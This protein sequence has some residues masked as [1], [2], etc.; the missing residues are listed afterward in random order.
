M[1]S[2][3]KY[4]V[5][6][7]VSSA[8]VGLML[9][10]DQNGKPAWQ[11]TDD[12]GIPAQYIPGEMNYAGLNP[13]S[14]FSISQNS[15]H[16]GI[17][18]LVYQRGS[19]MYLASMGV[20]CRKK[21]EVKI[22][23][24]CVALSYGTLP[25][26]TSLTNAGFE[27]YASSN[28]TSW[29]KAGLGTMSQEG[30][31]IQSGSYSAKWALNTNTGSLTQTL[32]NHHLMVGK[33]LT[34]T[35]YSRRSAALSL[36]TVGI[37][38][39]DV[40]V[41]H[42]HFDAN[43]DTWQQKTVTYTV[44]D[45][46]DD[47]ATMKVQ[48]TCEEGGESGGTNVYFDTVVA[49][50]DA[51]PS[52]GATTCFC[53][54]KTSIYASY[55]GGVGSYNS[56]TEAI[57]Y[58]GGMPM[59]PTWLSYW[60]DSAGTEYL[61]AFYTDKK[62]WSSPDAAAWTQITSVT[63][64]ADIVASGSDTKLWSALQHDD[65]RSASTPTSAFT[66]PTNLGSPSKH[67]HSLVVTESDIPY[68][69]KEDSIF[70]IDADGSHQILNDLKTNYPFRMAYSW[71]NNV[72]FSMGTS[73][74]KN[75]SLCIYNSLS[76]TIT[77]ISPAD[78]ASG[79]YE[80]TGA[81]YAITG[82][83]NWLYV[84][85]A[86]VGGVYASGSAG[87]YLL[88]GRWEDIEGNTQWV[89]HP[90]QIIYCY[91]TTSN[92]IK[93]PLIYNNKMF[94]PYGIDQLNV[95]TPQ[96]A[97][98]NVIATSGT[99]FTQWFD[100][101]FP[102]ENKAFITLELFTQNLDAEHTIAVSYQFWGAQT[103]NELDLAANWTTLATFNT[104]PTQTKFF[105]ANTYGKKIRFRLIFTT[106]DTVSPILNDFILKGVLRSAYRKRF[107]F[108]IR[109]SDDIVDLDGGIS[110]KTGAW[111]STQLWTARAAYWPMNLKYDGTTYTV[112][113][114]KLVESTQMNEDNRRLERLFQ[115]DA[116]EY[117]LS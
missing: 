51:Q 27:T 66:S 113:I 97:S 59:N 2:K 42:T 35:A 101:G 32:S 79:F 47:I 50:V 82:D 41:A 31:I 77:N 116:E 115:I 49:T 99:L 86:D 5:E 10:K 46:A 9:A 15:W 37:L 36:W 106:D 71:Q 84:M 14:G 8:T 22:G 103:T 17:G 70:Y 95:L 78:Y 4:D 55:G 108:A 16:G 100:L 88:A 12:T 92:N 93:V 57:D 69:F 102:G 53:E 61:I 58:I 63:T 67:I 56:T 38:R 104:S 75:A 105:A 94:L 33:L 48:L 1:K 65:I 45:T 107:T 34:V 98:L 29:T 64:Y 13:L 68:I 81:I 6:L 23:P 76:G 19:K 43:V 24:K 44:L 28:F 111:L 112:L 96:Y 114:D 60:H 74:T 110:K 40:E 109:A 54:F 26:L 39:N 117:T 85:V 18:E 21:G 52:A 80:C 7:T 30:T 91:I 3:T 89:W 72:I 62:A 25:T 20:D 87:Y 73:G 83:S 90:I 11:I